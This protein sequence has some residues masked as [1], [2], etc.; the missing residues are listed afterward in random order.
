MSIVAGID[1]GAKNVKVVILKDGRILAHHIT[2]AGLDTK[3]AC[4]ICM[5][6]ILDASGIKGSDIDLVASTGSGRDSIPWADLKVTEILSDAKGMYTLD[7]DCRTLVDIGAE[8]ARAISIKEGGKVSNFAIN[9][10]CAAGSGAFL[11]AMA[12][13][14]EVTLDEFSSIG[15]LSK[16][17]VPMNAQCVVFA[18]SEVVSMIHMGFS[19]ED[20]SKA[21]HEAIAERAAL[22]ISKIGAKEKI[23]AAGGVALSPCF[24]KTL[25][26]AVEKPIHVPEKISPMFVG[27]L[28]AG[29]LAL[30]S[31]KK[32][33]RT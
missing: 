21:I 6:E 17:K 12:R 15:L 24:L 26:E 2:E 1:V 5:K 32:G 14:L 25:E 18:E 20:I 16:R 11:E 19:K 33:G 30:E 27:A 3:K 7:P 13:A 22:M 29:M 8:E 23:Y 9:E 4:E 10:K 31:L 28:G